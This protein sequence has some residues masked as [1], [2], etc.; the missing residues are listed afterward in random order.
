[1]GRG[2]QG[3]FASQEGVKGEGVG[4][5]FPF[6]G[7]NSYLRWRGFRDEIVQQLSKLSC[8][9]EIFMIPPVG[10]VWDEEPVRQEY[11]E[12]GGAGEM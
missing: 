8:L 5:V 2:G 11:E 10:D 3:R 9:R 4:H 7:K 12:G 6:G 1:M